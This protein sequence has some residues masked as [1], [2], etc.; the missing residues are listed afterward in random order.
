MASGENVAVR[1]QPF[2]AP[3]RCRVELSFRTPGRP[4]A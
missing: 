1:L 2:V 4:D 3:G